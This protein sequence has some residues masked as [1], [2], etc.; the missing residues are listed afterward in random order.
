MM[1]NQKSLQKIAEHSRYAQ[2]VSGAMVAYSYD[3]FSRHLHK[4]SILELGPAEGVMTDLF[5]KSGRNL[6]VVE[7]AK[8]FCDELSQRYPSIQVHHALFEDF[9][10]DKKFE[11]IILGHV[12]EHVDD[13][14]F[15]LKH[16]KQFLKKNGVILAAVPNA[17]SIHRQAA[18][19]MGLLKKENSLN[20][21]DIYHGHKRVYSLP[22]V[23]RDF[24]RAGLK[25]R[26]AS[27]YWLKP[28]SN[29]Q[30]DEW[31]TP[32]MIDAFMK[33]GEKYPEIAAEIFIVAT[34]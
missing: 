15:V 27:G 17:H 31:W 18:V 30:I 6:T 14:V 16:V 4:G 1:D 22:E 12:L 25:I 20:E 32:E 19:E 23:R 29:K 7:G 21:L 9:H 24:E 28:V 10:V 2:G 8:K 11:N 3:V 5:V 33:L 26:K 13:P 34:V